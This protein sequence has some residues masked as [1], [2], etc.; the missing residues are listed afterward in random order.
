[1]KRFRLTLLLSVLLSLLLQVRPAWAVERFAVLVGDNRGESD[2]PD[3]RYAE[4]DA[5]SLYE[6]L[7]EVGG[8]RPENMLLLRGEPSKVVERAIISMNDR[9]R[10]VS[11]RANTQVM[12]L[13]YYSGHGDSRSL[14]LNRSTLELALL[15]QL[16]RSSAAAF[17]ILVVD[18]CRSGM[19][20]RVKGGVPAPAF[21]L[22]VEDTLNGEGVVFLTASS[23]NEDAQE[24]DGL[25]GSFFTHYF[26]SGLLG[27]ADENSDGRVTLDE[28]Y[29]YTYANTIRASSRTIAGTQHPT[30]N[31]ELRGQGSIV[32]SEPGAQRQRRATLRFPS[33]RS[34][35]LFSR[36]ANGRVMG[37]VGPHDVNRTMSVPE[38]TYF[39]RGRGS[40]HLLEG[41]VSV[42]KGQ[43]LDVEDDQLQRI[44]YA[45]LVRKGGAYRDIAHG[46]HSG[47]SFR[48][49]LANADA[50]CHGAFAG[51][52]FVLS[53]LSLSPRVEACRSFFE[54]VSL[55][56]TV[57][58]IGVS[59]RAGHAWDINRW[60]LELG[61]EAGGTVHRQRFDTDGL[62]PSRTTFGGNFGLGAGAA[63]AL[64]YGLS[65]FAETGVEANLFEMEHT[66]SGQR[67]AT[68]SLALRQRLGFSKLW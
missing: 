36:D 53:A 23:A 59:L 62:A 50:P 40:S 18:A 48:T 4:S 42:S 54:N 3:L 38:G 12:L 21:A 27:P 64:G 57:D 25:G 5:E 22:R 47:Y 33:G 67:T 58:S 41:T 16:V 60:S 19:L 9:I 31:Y 34:Y 15:E 46:P 55:S 17:R 35:L 68:A 30:F 52:S 8:F 10:G 28:V 26:R 32:L 66:D 24:A 20:T 65:L 51:Y 29:R 37:E 39:V 11:S 56:S 49:A 2:E 7:K 61:T 6:V 63:L 1:M 14:H 45:R 43:L 13:V 44:D